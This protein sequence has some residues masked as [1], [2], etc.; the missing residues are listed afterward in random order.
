MKL[1][2]QKGWPKE[3]VECMECGDWDTAAVFL[4]GR[5]T[6][7]RADRTHGPTCAV[8]VLP[9]SASEPLVEALEALLRERRRVGPKEV[10]PFYLPD[11]QDVRSA[12]DELEIKFA[13][14]KALSQEGE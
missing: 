10:G 2:S 9:V 8:P 1:D 6:C 5:K 13:A 14:F 12:L 3:I 4:R 11:N 7:T